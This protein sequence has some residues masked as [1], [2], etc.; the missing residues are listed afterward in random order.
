MKILHIITSLSNGGAEAVLYRLSTGDKK[1]TCQVISLMDTG[2]YGEQ[3][4]AAGI[5]VHTLNMPSGRVTLR[6]LLK[7][8]RLIRTI[9]P[10]VI[11]TWMYHAD[12][13]GGVVGRL[14]GNRAVVWGVRA[15]DA[16]TH[17]NNNIALA[18]V[19]WLCAKLSRKIPA[20]IIFASQA[21]A[22]VHNEMGY[23]NA[24]SVVIPNGYNIEELRPNPQTREMLR[25]EWHIRSGTIMIGMVAR[26][27]P[28]KDHENLIAGLYHLNA[29][30]S[31]DWLCALIGPDMTY[32]NRE[33][34]ELL[35][36]YGMERKIKLCGPHSDIPAVM[37]AIDIH[38]LSSKSEAFPNVVAEAMA[39]GTPCV[40]TD[41]GDSSVIVGETGWIVSPS[42]P[43]ALACALQES[44]W[45]MSD[46]VKWK[47]RRATCRSRIL[48]NY[49]LER[50][51]EEYNKVWKE[52]VRV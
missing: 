52:V 51:V 43:T 10:D 35:K 29:M 8:H 26:W 32:E 4:A 14:A 48:E 6:G 44:I 30:G 46:D 36:R 7:L 37:N 1:N 34:S 19:L 39:C 40:V 9:K 49:S 47:A 33:L 5:S 28:L 31:M 22:R 20:G 11:Q 42:D 23:L 21:G 15:S 12:L 24:K 17:N 45:E 27:D 13:I 16:H 25:A 2:F 50:I 18:L 41:V 38:V 3:L